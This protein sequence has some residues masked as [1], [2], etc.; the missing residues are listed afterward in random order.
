[1]LES[2]RST[3]PVLLG[4]IERALKQVG[5]PLKQ[6]DSS[7]ILKT[8]ELPFQ[9]FPSQL[10][11]SVDMWG[12]PQMSGDF[13]FIYPMGDEQALIVAMDIAGHSPNV[14]GK[15]LYVQ[16]WLRGWLKNQASIPRL[17]SVVDAISEEFRI[18]NIQGGAFLALLALDRN[19]LH[20]V[21]YEATCCGFPSPLLIIGPPFKTPNSP[22]VGPP[23]PQRPGML[24]TTTI[25]KLPAPWRII[26]SSDGML[27]RLE[28]AVNLTAL[29]IFSSGIRASIEMNPLR[30]A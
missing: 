10:P 1:M 9:S 24:Q 28:M 20:T 14:I 26:I 22:E 15:R 4:R 25:E 3:S 19:H 5:Q 12:R 29:N 23:L 13:F 6:P 16:G 18:T 17:Q 8:P 21:S 11:I 2:G 30:F 7:V 27:S